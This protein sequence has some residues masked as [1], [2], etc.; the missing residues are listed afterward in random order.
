MTPAPTTR[1]AKPHVCAKPQPV[2]PASGLPSALSAGGRVKPTSAP[3]SSEFPANT[4][5]PWALIRWSTIASP[6]PDPGI[7]QAQGC[8]RGPSGLDDGLKEPGGSG[9]TVVRSSTAPYVSGAGESRARTRERFGVCWEEL[10]KESATWHWND[11]GSGLG[12]DQRLRDT[13]P[14]TPWRN[15][16]RGP[17]AALSACADYGEAA[18]PVGGGH[19]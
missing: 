13:R 17:Y 8:S 4:V 16:G 14:H 10:S 3:P 19:E 15:Y 2:H 7:E 5:P 18:Q 12:D 11:G 1:T 9:R 6:R